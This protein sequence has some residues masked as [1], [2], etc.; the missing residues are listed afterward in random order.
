MPNSYQDIVG[1]D[2]YVFVML[3][4]NSESL[5][6]SSGE[7]YPSSGLYRNDGSNNP[8][9]TV[10]WF[11]FTVYVSSDGQHIARMGPWPSLKGKREP[12]VQ[13]LA[14]AFYENGELLKRYI[15]SDLI[16]KP[17]SLPSSVSHFEWKKD[18]SFDDTLERLTIIT[19]EENKYVFDI[20]SGEMVMEAMST[21]DST[22]EN[23]GESTVRFL[24]PLLVLGG[25]GLAII[26][27]VLLWRKSVRKV[28]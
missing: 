1:N 7:Q 19:T 18:V 28:L 27:V 13:E 15:I 23:I 26:V 8:L 3:V 12:D 9:W 10:D 6:S 24:I 22:T 16:S 21:T 20:K 2:Q 4:E 14:V 5:I 25:I 17:K 11:A